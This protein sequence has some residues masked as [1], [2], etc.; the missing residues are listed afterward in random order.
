MFSQEEGK[1][2]AEYWGFRVLEMI[3]WRMGSQ[4]R[5]LHLE[6]GSVLFIVGFLTW[7]SACSVRSR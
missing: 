4:I 5:G 6:A 1:E 2:M 7:T 3:L